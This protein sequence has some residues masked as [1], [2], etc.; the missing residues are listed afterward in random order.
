M[1]INF[2]LPRYSFMGVNRK[3]NYHLYLKTLELSL[4]DLRRAR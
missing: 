1:Y 2:L 3:T 4:N